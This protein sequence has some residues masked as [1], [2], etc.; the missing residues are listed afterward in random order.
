MK[1]E[2]P[3]NADFFWQAG[4]AAFSVSQSNAPAVLRYIADQ[5]QHH[6]AWSYQDEVRELLKKHQVEFDE[7]YLWE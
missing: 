2:G 1:N 7:R 6:R 4:Y 5:E 3:R